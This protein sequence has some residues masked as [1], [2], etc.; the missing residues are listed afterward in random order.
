[1]TPVICDECG[2][3]FQMD[4]QPTEGYTC[5][6]MWRNSRLYLCAKCYHASIESKPFQ[7]GECKTADPEDEL[8]KECDDDDD[9]DEVSSSCAYDDDID[10]D[11]ADGNIS[12]RVEFPKGPG[13]PIRLIVDEEE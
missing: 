6:D 5:W 10:D 11:D 3:P 12:P 13:Y 7:S 1:M 4:A 8:N 2:K 9:D